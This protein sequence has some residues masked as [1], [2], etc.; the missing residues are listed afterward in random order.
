[1]KELYI[2]L[3]DSLVDELKRRA[4]QREVTVEEYVAKALRYHLK[5]VKKI[6]AGLENDHQNLLQIIGQDGE[7]NTDD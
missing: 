4:E 6:E 3:K 7:P 5:Q 1:M 2:T